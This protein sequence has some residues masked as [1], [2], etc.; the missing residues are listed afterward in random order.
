MT[1]HAGI[2]IG[3]FAKNLALNWKYKIL[4]DEIA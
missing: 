4:K 2:F 1:I 3:E